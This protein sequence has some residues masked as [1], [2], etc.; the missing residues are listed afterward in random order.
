MFCL[1]CK[2]SF[3]CQSNKNEKNSYGKKYIVLT[4]KLLEY[5]K[6]KE[7]SKKIKNYLQENCSIYIFLSLLAYS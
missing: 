5:L 3:T 6:K 1:E 4:D 2:E 7:N